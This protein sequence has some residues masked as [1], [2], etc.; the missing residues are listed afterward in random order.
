M[1]KNKKKKSHKSKGYH[2]PKPGNPILAAQKRQLTIDHLIRETEQK[3]AFNTQLNLLLQLA[4]D[5][6]LISTAEVRGLGP[7]NAQKLRVTFRERVNEMSAMLADDEDTEAVYG[8]AKIDQR[9]AQIEGADRA[10][11]WDERTEWCLT[12]LEVA[13]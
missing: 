2:K 8:R 3:F 12:K 13:K 11:S 1:S 10:R 6:C 7:D 5:A 9:L 4:E